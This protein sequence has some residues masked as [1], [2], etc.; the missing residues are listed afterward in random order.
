MS[1]KAQVPTKAAETKAEAPT[2]E[3]EAND[4]WMFKTFSKKD[5]PKAP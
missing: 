4:D 1:E 3:P 5:Q 2:P